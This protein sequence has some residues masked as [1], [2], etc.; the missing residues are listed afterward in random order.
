MK[1]K[2]D[3][4]I[5]SIG[6]TVCLEALELS[7]N[8]IYDNLEKEE[9]LEH[10]VTALE[11]VMKAITSSEDSTKLQDQFDFDIRNMFTYPLHDGSFVDSLTKTV[12]NILDLYKIEGLSAEKTAA[13]S[14][15]MLIQGY[16]LIATRLEQKFLNDENYHYSE[17]ASAIDPV[18][19]QLHSLCHVLRSKSVLIERIES[20]IAKKLG[21]EKGA[22]TRAARFES[23]K[24]VVIE[25]FIAMKKP[26]TSTEA[27]RNIYKKLGPESTWLKDDESRQLLKDPTIRFTQ[28]IRDFRKQTQ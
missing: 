22:N 27:A 12:P 7:S 18:I 14:Q 26:V 6:K 23:L 10:A 11:N 1:N 3:S 17:F 19:Y 4:V 15:A 2:I 8:L 24:E 25:E 16:V 28:W 13:I 5:P 21:G 9:Y 20:K